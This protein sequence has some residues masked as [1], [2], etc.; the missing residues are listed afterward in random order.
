MHPE[1]KSAVSESVYIRA[2]KTM[3][4]AY[5]AEQYTLAAEMFSGI[6][7]YKDSAA[8]AENCRK[9]AEEH[10]KKAGERQ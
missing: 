2:V 4:R 3:D 9:M 8:L 1:E 6:A 10:M 5:L 7:D